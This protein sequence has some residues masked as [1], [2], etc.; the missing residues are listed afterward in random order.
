L[1]PDTITHN[2]L[3]NNS[4]AVLEELQK[5]KNNVSSDI[6]KALHSKRLFIQ[7]NHNPIQN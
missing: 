2:N 5:A 4:S 3:Q 7:E 6:L 1:N